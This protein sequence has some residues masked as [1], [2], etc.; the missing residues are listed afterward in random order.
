MIGFLIML[1]VQVSV[2]DDFNQEQLEVREM[3]ASG[4][5][6]SLDEI[7]SALQKELLGHHLLKVKLE[8]KDDLPVYELDFVSP[9]GEVLEIEVDAS[10]GT[11]IKQK[12]E[13]D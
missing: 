4:K 10:S 8:S 3:L 11:I 12:I 5:I 6:L 9:G 13:T 1:A 2:A 7:L